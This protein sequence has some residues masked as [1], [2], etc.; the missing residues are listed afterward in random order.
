MRRLPEHSCTEF[1]ISPEEMARRK[2]AFTTLSLTVFLSITLCAIDYLLTEPRI[3]WPCIAGLGLL[4][5]LSRHSIHKSTDKFGRRRVVISKT[6]VLNVSGG[7]ES[8]IRFDEIRCMRIKTTVHGTIREIVLRASDGT[9][10]GISGVRDFESLRNDLTVR[11]SS[12]VEVS[13]FN[14]LIDFDHPL[15]YVVFGALVGCGVVGMMRL[16]PSLSY[17]NARIVNLAISVFVFFAGVHWI[18]TKPGAATYGQNV[19]KADRIFGMTMI[20]IAVF[21]SVHRLFMW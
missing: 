14:E 18:R 12:E 10:F 4:L 11:L 17:E 19:A 3:A 20:L 2:R 15:F 7:T 8:A 13:E 5:L 9:R 6:S 16:A 1:L 21:L